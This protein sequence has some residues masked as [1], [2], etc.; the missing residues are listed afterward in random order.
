[1]HWPADH[2]L[3]ADDLL[4]RW[5][6]AADR[7][8]GD[9]VVLRVLKHVPGRRVATLVS[10]PDGLAVLKVFSSPRAR[11]NDRRLRA[12]GP[13]V[14]DLLPRARQVDPLGHVGLLSYLPGRP[15]DGLSGPPF[16]A[17]CGQAGAALARLH[18]CGVVLDRQWT[19]ADELAQ[20]R[21]MATPTTD[22]AISRAVRSLLPQPDVP[23]GPAHRDLHL[24]QVVVQPAG[25]AFID[26]D[27][28]TM[29]PPGL[30]VGNLLG[31]LRQEAALGRRPAREVADAATAFLTSYGGAP[32]D[33]DCWQQLTLARLAALADARFDRPDWTAALLLVLA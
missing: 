33:T 18:G 24:A 6:G 5:R 11:G 32:P 26:L 8:C 4:A 12:L 23:L 3:H 20:L 17:A 25:V 21:S 7:L 10:T 9:G 16:I 19:A 15:L 29:A 2:P 1:M 28:A 30:D 13:A 31:H 14:G 27:E 22:A